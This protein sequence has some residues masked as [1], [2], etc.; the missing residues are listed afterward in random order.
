M[1][2]SHESNNNY[3]ATY[4][5]NLI[6]EQNTND[7]DIIFNCDDGSGGVTAYLTLDG[8][9]NK[10]IANENIDIVTSS[11]EMMR[12]KRSGANQVSIEQDSSQLYF[13]NRATSKT[14]F[15]MSNNGSAR[16]G[17]NS[18]PSLELRNTATSTGSG[19]SLIFGHD[20]SGTN[21]VARIS[22]Y[23]TDGSQSGR[24]GH[25]RFWTRRSGTEELAMQLQHDKKLRLYQQGDTTDYL[26]LYVD[27]TRAYYHHAHTGSSGAYHRFETDNGYIE[28]GP[29][30][31]GWG[32]INTDRGK[33]YFNNKIIVDSGIVAAYDEDL[34]LRRNFSSSD[35]VNDRIDIVDNAV[36]V[37]TDS[38]NERFR[39]GSVNRSFNNLVVGPISNN[40]KAYIRANNGYS[41]ATTPDYTWWYND[42][43]GIYHPAGNTIGFSASGQKVLISTYGLYSADDI[44]INHGGSDYSPGLQFMGGSNTPGANEY[45]NA[46]LAYYDNSGTGLMRYIIGRSAGSH[47]FYIGGTEKVSID[48]NRMYVNSSGANGLVINNDTGT[49]SNSGRIFFEGT[50]TSAIFQSGNALSFRTGASSGSSSGTQRFYIDSSGTTF[51]GDVSVDGHITMQSGHYIT[52]HNESDY[53]KFRMYGGSGAYA[54]GMKSGNTYGGL[55]DWAMTFTFNDDADRGFLWRD[56]SHG[57]NG[58]AMGLTTNGKLTVAHSAR[59]GYYGETDTTT[60]G[61]TYR[62]DVSGSIGATADVVVYISSDKKFKDNIKNIENPLEKLQ[63]LNGVEFDWNNK[64]DLYEGHDI[65]V[66]AQE[67]EEVIPESSR[68]RYK[69]RWS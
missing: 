36:K 42:Q 2:L 9:A 67:V 6:L 1:Q 5:G 26:E 13:Y 65:G 37:Y 63:K 64:Q 45:E 24:A 21:S 46:K 12:F 41:T 40:S 60:P 61:S 14:M 25:L 38:Q 49:T 28:L 34:S 39:F 58:G 44:Y 31:T 57:T 35:G 47:K 43:C 17:H 56:T 68:S 7:A 69:K 52:A 20:Q 27:D 32:H 51:T 19:P 59:I 8:S 33:F 53:A 4:A 18:N 66:I 50:S 29:A 11:D 23:L 48:N 15:L 30:N 54:I 22:S 3:I 16:L 62:L 55:G 10:I